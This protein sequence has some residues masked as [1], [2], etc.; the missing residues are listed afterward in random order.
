MEVNPLHGKPT[1]NQESKQDLFESASKEREEDKIRT[2]SGNILP[3]SVGQL[4]NFFTPSPNLSTNQLVSKPP[5]E[6]NRKVHVQPSMPGHDDSKSVNVNKRKK[7]SPTQ[8]KLKT[9]VKKKRKANPLPSRRKKTSSKS[10]FE[11]ASSDSSS[12]KASPEKSPKVRQTNSYSTCDILNQS[13]DSATNILNTQGEDKYTKGVKV[14]SNPLVS[15]DR[16]CF[17]SPRIV[18]TVEKSLANK[19]QSHSPTQMSLEEEKSARCG[20]MDTLEEDKSSQNELMDVR[21]VLVMFQTL[22][23]EF[24]SLKNELKADIG[25]LQNSTLISE[26]L[27]KQC[28]EEALQNFSDEIEDDR[29]KVERLEAEL[30]VSRFQNQVLSQCMDRFSMQLGDVMG[31]LDNLELNNSK[32]AVMLTGLYAS[33]KKPEMREETE[34]FFN[35]TLGFSPNIDD[36]YQLGNT[37]PKPIVILLPTL[38]EKRK[39]MKAKAM[40]NNYINEDKKKFYLQDYSPP[41]VSEKKRREKEIVKQNNKLENEEKLQI[42]FTKQG[43]KI[44]GNTY[45]KKVVAPTPTD[46]VNADLE[47]YDAMMNVRLNKGEETIEKNS[48]FIAYNKAVNSHEE[49]RILYKRLRMTNPAARHIVCAYWIEGKEP[50]Y[51]KDFYDDEEPGAGRIILD[52]M[53]RNNMK[54]RVFFAVR[55][56]GGIRMGADRFKCYIQAVE[57]SIR[58]GDFNH[59][60][61]QQQE[62]ASYEN[63][64]E[65]DMIYEESTQR[66]EVGTEENAWHAGPPRAYSPPQIPASLSMYRNSG[67]QRQPVRARGR[68]GNYRGAYKY[69]RSDQDPSPLPSFSLPNRAQRI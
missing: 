9:V 15:I 16:F 58:R 34:T 24:S 56:Y 21:S 26:D 22:Q 12:E 68:G 10:H 33:H 2:P 69:R 25:K 31:R 1:V 29:K 66:K 46:L 62:L 8:G 37:D 44:Q 36:I 63:R 64:V 61:N 38:Q 57:A 32:Y 50:H 49:I 23:G 65:Q 39:L 48:R 7:A 45:R 20:E 19:S 53:L 3:K 59:H 40:L 52:W 47:E 6:V 60:L 41:V 54:C 4:R 17:K 35:Q 11:V 30:K 55:Y 42:E 51:C 27:K 5:R 28:K 43:L 67:F 14:Q 13:F 18:P